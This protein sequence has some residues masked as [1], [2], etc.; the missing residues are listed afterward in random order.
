MWLID[1][2]RHSIVTGST[3]HRYLALSYEWPRDQTRSQS[4]PYIPE[5]LLDN[6]NIANF[7]EPQFLR[8]KE[9]WESVP[10]VIRHAIE[11]TWA[12]NERFL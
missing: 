2:H 8:R 4:S 12:L 9:I 11:L 3:A 6:A 7:R 1:T 5:L 10:Y